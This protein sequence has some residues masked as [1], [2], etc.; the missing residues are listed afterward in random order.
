MFLVS[1]M[2]HQHLGVACEHV[3]KLVDT[4]DGKIKE[5]DEVISEGKQLIKE[6]KSSRGQAS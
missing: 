5:C 1:V 2:V 6:L 4:L 3:D